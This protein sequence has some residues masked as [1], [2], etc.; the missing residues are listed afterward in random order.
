MTTSKFISKFN[1][2]TLISSSLVLDSTILLSNSVYSRDCNLSVLTIIVFQCCSKL[3]SLHSLCTYL[4]SLHYSLLMQFQ[5]WSTRLQSISQRGLNNQFSLS[6]ITPLKYN[7]EVSWPRFWCPHQ[8][9]LNQC[10]HLYQMVNIYTYQCIE[11][12]E[13]HININE[14]L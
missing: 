3:S 13:D 7:S 11:K 14:I 6:V 5:N 2:L 10:L 9:T 4:G 1:Q 12:N 8:I